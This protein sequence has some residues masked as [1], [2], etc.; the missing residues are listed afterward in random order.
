MNHWIVSYGTLVNKK[1]TDK[2]GNS[3]EYIP[4]LIHN[5]IRRWSFSLPSEKRSAA[6]IEQKNNAFTTGMLVKI[7]ES[8]LPKFDKREKG[9]TRQRVVDRKILKPLSKSTPNGNFWLYVQN[10]AKIPTNKTPISQ[11]MVDV[12]VD[13]HLKFSEEFAVQFIETTLDWEKPWVNDRNNPLYP[14][15]LDNLPIKKIDMLLKS[16]IPQHFAKRI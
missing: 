13:A 4:C 10:I 11:T 5:H 16:T 9:Y 1:I 15:Y 3:S 6:G 2:T 7:P 8:E 14:R 12:I